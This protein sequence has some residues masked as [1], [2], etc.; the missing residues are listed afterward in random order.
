MFSAWARVSAG[1]R[2]TPSRHPK[3]QESL[4]KGLFIK[5][6]RVGGIERN[7]E[8]RG[9]PPAV[10]RDPVLPWNLRAAG[11]CCW[12]KQALPSWHRRKHQGHPQPGP[13]VGRHN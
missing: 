7:I 6:G 10:A 13:S 5:R 3:G 12:S 9:K 8:G 2:Y 1:S 11:E 4:R